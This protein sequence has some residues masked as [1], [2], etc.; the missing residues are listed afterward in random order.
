LFCL[1]TWFSY[2]LWQ[3]FRL[4]SGIRAVWWPAMLIGWV[5]I[6]VIGFA[7]WPHLRSMRWLLPGTFAYIFALCILWPQANARYLV[8]VAPLIVLMVLLGL[9]TLSS[10]SGKPWQIRASAILAYVGVGSVVICNLALWGIDLWVM[11]SSHFYDRYEAGVYKPLLA[12]AQYLSDHKVGNWQTCVNPEY[13]NYNKRKMSPTGL[14]ILTMLTGKSVLQLPKQYTTA[15][16]K[17]PND[18]EFRRNFVA[19]GHVRYYLEQPP[20]SPWRL[21]HFRVP[22]LQKLVTHQPP[23]IPPG[24]DGWRLYVCDGASSPIQIPLPDSI[25]YPTRVPGF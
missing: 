16:Y 3:P 4:A 10:A 15:R 8:P 12:A 14:R 2:L 21:Q 24:G 25:T 9:Q 22:W 20:V 13:I 11:R 5:V 23:E 6:G 7:I 17:L 18:R 19:K 1:G